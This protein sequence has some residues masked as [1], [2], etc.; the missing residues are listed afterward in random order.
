M[1]EPPQRT[2][3]V[4][5]P[6]VSAVHC[7]YIALTLHHNMQG[8][9]GSDVARVWLALMKTVVSVHHVKTYQKLGDLD[10]TNGAVL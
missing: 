10:A 9:R 2:G 1:S 5:I 4:C 7:T 3:L 8:E 6:R